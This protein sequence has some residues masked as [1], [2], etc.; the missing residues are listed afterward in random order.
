MKRTILTIVLCALAA[1]VFGAGGYYIG[2]Q[3]N[4]DIAAAIPREEASMPPAPPANEPETDPADSITYVTRSDVSAAAEGVWT[5]V[6]EFETDLTGDGMAD[7]LTIYTSAESDGSEIMWDDGQSWVAEITDAQGGYYT[8]MNSYVNNGCVYAE[9]SENEKRDK[10]A[11]IIVTNGAGLSLKRYKY[12]SSGFM[13]N[14][15]V[16]DTAGNVIYSSVPFY[17]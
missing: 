8:L 6:S 17:K 4:G 10:E 15:L 2:K 1:A 13:E 3:S 14:K 5:K 9:I 11:T 12:S 16:D 7:K